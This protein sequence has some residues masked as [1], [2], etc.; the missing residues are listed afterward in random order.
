M[1]HNKAAQ[2]L[3]N[4]LKTAHVPEPAAADVAAIM[5]AVRTIGPLS[6]P[7]R[8]L[9]ELVWPTWSYAVAALFMGLLTASLVA[10]MVQWSGTHA[11]AKFL[12]TPDFQ[13]LISL[14]PMVVL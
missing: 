12:W 9:P 10:S 1:K 5:R 13:A 4:H 8:S 3:W 7:V 14:V 2:N 11:L 6:P